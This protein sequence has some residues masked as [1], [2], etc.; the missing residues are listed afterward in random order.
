MGWK[1]R[2]GGEVGR[3]PWDTTRHMFDTEYSKKV[4][5]HKLFF[6]KYLSLNFLEKFFFSQYLVKKQIQ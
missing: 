2:G 1:F 3:V 4:L 5:G 6:I